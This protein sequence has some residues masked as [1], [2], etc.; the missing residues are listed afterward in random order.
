MDV[1]DIPVNA[2]IY[3]LI[4][5]FAEEF[6]LVVLGRGWADLSLTWNLGTL[7]LSIPTILYGATHSAEGIALS[8]LCLSIVLY[9]P[10][11]YVLVKPLCNFTLREYSLTSLRPIGLSTIS[12]V[13]VLLFIEQL[14]TPGFRLLIGGVCYL[15]A[16]LL[17][18]YLFN[19]QWLVSL[20]E[21][22]NIRRIASN[23]SSSN[24]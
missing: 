11:W 24:Q 4:A 5:L 8:L 9:I 12:L 14:E 22:F 16:Y 17:S 6:T 20:A 21:I 18:T 10:G 3:F 7:L 1:R 2:P 13:P 15:F 23:A 19:R